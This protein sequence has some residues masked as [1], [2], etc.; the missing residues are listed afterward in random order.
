MHEVIFDI[1]TKSFF[2]ETKT[3]PEDLGVSI[4]SLYHRTVDTAGQ[5]ISGEMVS[6]WDGEFDRMWKLFLEADRIIGF[7]TLGFDVPALIPFA[8][9]QWP[10]LPHF[11]ILAKIKEATGHRTSLNKIAKQTLKIGKIDSGENAILYWEKH[12]PESL[13]LLKKYCEMDV[14]ITRDIYDYVQKHK[15]LSFID[16]WNNPREVELDFSYPADVNS[17]TQTALF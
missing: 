8:P 17:L 15:K 11:D 3:K 9:T 13:A 14:A 1:E 16:H 10:K 12:D 4:V 7:N 6:F 2:D 5:E